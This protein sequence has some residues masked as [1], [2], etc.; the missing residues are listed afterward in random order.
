MDLGAYPYQSPK[1]HDNSLGFVGCC[2]RKT[3]KCVIA[4]DEAQELAAIS[5]RLLKLLANIFNTHPNIVFIFTGSMFGLMKI[6]LEPASSS[7]LYGRSPAKIYLSSTFP[8][9]NF[10]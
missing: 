7:P 5:G 1:T 6:L 3:E 9:R 10:H 2:R 4:L 8:E